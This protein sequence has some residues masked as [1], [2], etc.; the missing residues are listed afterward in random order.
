MTYVGPI[1]LGGKDVTLNGTV[2]EIY[3]QIKDLTGSVLKPEDSHD[4]HSDRKLQ[5]RS[6]ILLRSNLLMGIKMIKISINCN[7]QGEHAKMRAIRDGIKYLKG[8]RGMC[9]T[10]GLNCYR[11][12]CSYGSGIFICNDTS[13]T[14][15]VSCRDLASYA[16]DIVDMCA[17]E[18]VGTAKGQEFDSA[19][20][21]VIVKKGNC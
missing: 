15:E 2:Q 7:P 1:K 21:N 17:G 12:S 5:T 18:Y 6:K 16:Q 4:H 20:F 11:V 19:G 9:S 13:H 14:V 3:S 10:P 8:L